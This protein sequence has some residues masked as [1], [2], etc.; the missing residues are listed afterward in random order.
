MPWPWRPPVISSPPRLI[1][2]PDPCL[3]MPVN[4]DR[5]VGVFAHQ[6]RAVARDR[7]ADR[8]APHRAVANHEAGEKILILAGG[9]AVPKLDA[10]GLIPGAF[11][12]VPRAVFGRKRIASVLSGELRAGVEGELQRGGVRLDQHVRYGDLVPELAPLAAMVRILVGAD[13]KPRPAVEGALAHAR[14]EIRHQV[15]AEAVALVRRAPQ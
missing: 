12:A 3:L 14:D 6:Q 13:V 10:D 7:D 4:P 11:G 9:H 5:P 1:R 2:I 8:P 15:V